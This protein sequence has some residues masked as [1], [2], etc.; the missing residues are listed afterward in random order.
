M[1]YIKNSASE[2]RHHIMIMF[3][4][5][6]YAKTSMTYDAIVKTSVPVT[7]KH[8][9]SQ[10]K[11]WNLGTVTH[12]VWMTFKIPNIPLWERI[13]AFMII[14]QFILMPL[15]M[16]CYGRFIA[17]MV[18]YGKGEIPQLSAYFIVLLALAAFR[19]TFM[20][21]IGIVTPGM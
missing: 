10:R 2:D 6:G 12:N 15:L 21:G 20:I 7:I 19:L 3:G 1:E 11:R 4:L 5:Y 9:L 13:S 16:F 17:L 18:R 8:F 14:L